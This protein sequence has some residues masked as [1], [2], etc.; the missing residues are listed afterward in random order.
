MSHDDF[1]IIEKYYSL[2]YS[3]CFDSCLE[4]SKLSLFFGMFYLYFLKLSAG[5]GLL[6][7]IVSVFDDVL[8]VYVGDAAV[9]PVLVYVRYEGT[10]SVTV[11]ELADDLDSG[12]WKMSTRN[13]IPSLK[14]AFNGKTSE[15]VKALLPGHFASAG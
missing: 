14:Q 2:T 10:E 9:D 7:C 11:T 6:T 8:I 1:V 4:F 12:R 3:S 15:R 5:R 13:V